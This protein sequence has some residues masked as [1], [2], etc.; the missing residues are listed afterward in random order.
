ML[1]L[2]LFLGYEEFPGL[3]TVV[4]RGQG[5]IDTYLGLIFAVLGPQGMISDAGKSFICGCLAYDSGR[6]PTARQAFRHGWLQ[7]PHSDRKVFK[8]LETDNALL[9]KPQPVKF[10][11]VEDLT[12]W[13]FG[14]GKRQDGDGQASDEAISPHFM[15]PEQAGTD[16][17]R[18]VQDVNDVQGEASPVL[19]PVKSGLVHAKRKGSTSNTE[20]AKRPK[21][22]AC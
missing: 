8:R 13:S 19:G 11:V 9:W 18:R 22:A 10:P 1:T 21:S 17:A 3:D 12:A 20:S 14:Q 7:E 5:E 16:T 2:Q 6:R 15:S 4:F